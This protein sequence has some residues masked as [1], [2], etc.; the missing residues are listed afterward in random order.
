MEHLWKP[1][2]TSLS[3]LHLKLDI[4]DDKSTSWKQT[5]HGKSYIDTSPFRFPNAGDISPSRFN[6]DRFLNFDREG[7]TQKPIKLKDTLKH[8]KRKPWSYSSELK[9]FFGEGILTEQRHWRWC[10][11]MWPLATSSSPNPPL[12]SNR[13]RHCL[14]CGTI[15]WSPRALLLEEEKY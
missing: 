14:H 10:C 2:R 8:R 7:K 15:S 3:A 12:R 6:P 5:A 4:K 11:R 9:K 13:T 1:S